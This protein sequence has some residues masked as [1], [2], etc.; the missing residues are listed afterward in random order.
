MTTT[1]VTFDFDGT[2]IRRV[3]PCAHAL[4]KSAPSAA[5]ATCFQ[6]DAD[7]DRIEHH[8]ETDALAR[9]KMSFCVCGITVPNAQAMRPRLQRKTI[10][11]YALLLQLLAQKP[12]TP[13]F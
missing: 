2:L 12:S 11:C 7:I 3:G 8:G 13:F 6:L 5:R 1:R 9:N 10:E 4:F